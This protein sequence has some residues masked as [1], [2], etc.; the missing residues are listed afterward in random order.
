MGSIE[1]GTL[2]VTHFFQFLVIVFFCKLTQFLRYSL[3]TL[4]GVLCVCVSS[5]E[6]EDYV[7]VG[8]KF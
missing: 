7:L 1:E 4:S 2:R 3:K 6:K 5:M 8:K